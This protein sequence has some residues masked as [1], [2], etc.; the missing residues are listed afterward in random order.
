MSS[1]ILNFFLE[2]YVQTVIVIGYIIFSSVLSILKWRERKE[3]REFLSSLKK[4]VDLNTLHVDQILYPNKVKNQMEE[5]LKKY[6]KI[7]E[8]NKSNK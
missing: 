1:N 5:F 8:S 7:P 4:R 3:L 2:N 6:K